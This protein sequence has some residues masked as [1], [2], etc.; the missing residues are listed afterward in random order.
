VQ[1]VDKVH[2]ALSDAVDELR[3][4]VTPLLRRSP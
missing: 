2:E 3:S 1:A 4:R